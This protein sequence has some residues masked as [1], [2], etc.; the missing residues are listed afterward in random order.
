MGLQWLI[1]SRSETMEIGDVTACA[2]V[3]VA[4]VRGQSIGS[5]AAAHEQDRHRTAAQDVFR[6]TAHDDSA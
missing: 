1:C 5:F 6:V 3:T 2:A 4:C